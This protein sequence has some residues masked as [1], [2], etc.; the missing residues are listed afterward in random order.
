MTMIQVMEIR[1]SAA[2]VDIVASPRRAKQLKV[3]SRASADRD[4]KTLVD[5][6][7]EGLQQ[8]VKDVAAEPAAKRIDD[9]Y[10]SGKAD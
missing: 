4:T 5:D 8:E 6:Q 7:P 3:W 1:T 10:L 9:T 2:T